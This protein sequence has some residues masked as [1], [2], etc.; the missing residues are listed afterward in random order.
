M[1]K[2]LPGCV[3]GLRES[4][5][6]AADSRVRLQ[7]G[8]GLLVDRDLRL[9]GDLEQFVVPGG[10]GRQCFLCWH[11]RRVSSSS[12]LWRDRRVRSAVPELRHRPGGHGHL[13]QGPHLPP[14]RRQ[15]D[16]GAEHS[17]RSGE[18]GRHQG[19][20]HLLGRLLQGP[21]LC[22]Q[23]SEGTPYCGRAP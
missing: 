2:H 23:H 21:I 1:W 3:D 8:P 5:H 14:D 19:I 12:S 17:R 11:P 15:P 10:L 16:L 18:R 20:R 9:G 4:M 7:C 22:A 6:Q 13:G